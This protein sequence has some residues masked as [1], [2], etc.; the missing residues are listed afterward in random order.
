MTRVL[1]IEQIRPLMMAVLN[2]FPVEEAEKAFRL[3]LSWSVRFLVVGA[4]GG[5]TLERNYGILSQKVSDGEIKKAREMRDALEALTDP[6]FE[7]A[8]CAYCI[9]NAEIARYVCRSLEGYLRSEIEPAVIYFENVATANLEHV[10]PRV[11]DGWDVPPDVAKGY[12]NRVGNL[13]MLDPQANTRVGNGI[14]S[15]KKPFY[16]AL[17]FMITQAISKFDRWGAPEIE[18]RQT[19]LATYA[20]KVCPLTWK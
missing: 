15:T 20:P 8:F 3:M 14:F 17:P 1:G 11:A 9:S 6:Q 4:G 13:T 5:G 12:F 7:S 10:M 18:Q 19:L 16:A 2:R